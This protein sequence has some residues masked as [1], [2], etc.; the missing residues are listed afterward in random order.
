ML[1]RFGFRLIPIFC[2]FTS[3]LKNDAY[4]ESGQ[5]WLKNDISTLLLQMYETLNIYK[6]SVPS[7]TMALVSFFSHTEFFALSVITK[8]ILR[9]LLEF[10]PALR[11]GKTLRL[12]IWLC[13][14]I[15][16]FTSSENMSRP[17]C[18]KK[19]RTHVGGF[20]Y[21]TFWWDL[22]FCPFFVPLRLDATFLS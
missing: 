16:S 17:V 8:Q 15:Y 5:K 14:C 1:W 11:H 12:M 21:F 9:L 4:F 3:C 10:N 20:F 7:V 18:R 6:T 19:L 2:L 13:I 22:I